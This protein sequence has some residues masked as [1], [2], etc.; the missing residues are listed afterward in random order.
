MGFGRLPPWRAGPLARPQRWRRPSP[1]RRVGTEGRGCYK[2]HQTPQRIDWHRR[3]L[4]S[5]RCGGATAF[6]SGERERTHP[7]A[8]VRRVTRLRSP[9]G[10][11]FACLV[12]SAWVSGAICFMQQHDGMGRDA[13]WR[14]F[15]LQKA[16]C[17]PFSQ[18]IYNRVF[19]PRRG[20]PPPPT[21]ATSASPPTERGA[22]Q[23]T[24]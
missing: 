16:S 21:G 14:I 6:F 7:S 4:F 2:G 10:S 17:Q 20:T 3:R 9:M 5:R 15:Y 13:R 19:S 11:R 8:Y 1:P 18:A 24:R 23:S 12:N 22:G